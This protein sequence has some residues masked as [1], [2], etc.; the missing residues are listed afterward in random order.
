MT[1]EQAYR[2]LG[3]SKGADAKGVQ[4]AYRK[5]ALE[6]HPDRAATDEERKIFTKRFMKI[7]DAYAHLRDNGF[8]VPAPEE[9]VEDPIELR[10]YHR[11]FAKPLQ[12]KEERT[13]AET[14]GINFEWSPEQIIL[15][16]IVM[17]GG[18]YGTFVFL[19]FLA[20]VLR[21]E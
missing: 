21:G 12:K 3:V 13:L 9:V 2:V 10:T 7:R 8:P 15:W 1:D 17:P 5:R 19:R 18:A 16:A 4:N 6:A 11:D 14:L 20:G